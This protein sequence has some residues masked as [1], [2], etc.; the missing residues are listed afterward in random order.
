M[1]NKKGLKKYT[2]NQKNMPEGK[3]FREAFEKDVLKKKNPQMKKIKNA[4]SY[5]FVA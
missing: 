3:T 1:N 4:R 2:K 5:L